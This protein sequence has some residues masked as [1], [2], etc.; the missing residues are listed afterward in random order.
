MEFQCLQETL[1]FTDET[2]IVLWGNP[3][4]IMSRVHFH[5]SV[6]LL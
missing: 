1:P 5:V 2:E 3:M 6:Y 4:L